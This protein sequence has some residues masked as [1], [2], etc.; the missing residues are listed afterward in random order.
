MEL[1]YGF[2]ETKGFTAAVEAADAMLKAAKV[3]LV[4]W[5][6]TGGA[7]V[8]IIIQGDLAACQAA[9]S[10]GSAAAGLKGGL[11][12]SNIIAR[13]FGDTHTLVEEL[14]GSPR[15]LHETKQ[16][17]SENPPKA[18]SKKPA[19]AAPRKTKPAAVS[20]EDKILAYLKGKS[21]GASLQD[22]SKHLKQTTIQTR[23]LIKQLL[24]TARIEKI[25]NLYFLVKGRAGK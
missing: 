16:P 19:P 5:H 7:M 24:D 2:I 22:I 10:A 18:V 17:V 3:K 23:L 20:A 13:P 6:K 25:R 8:I 4:K 14:I 9:V 15:K 12:S 21:S 1:S 11:V